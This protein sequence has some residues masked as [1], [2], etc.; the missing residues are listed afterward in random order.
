MTNTRSAL[1]ARFR[2]LLSDER[3][4]TAIEYTIMASGIAMA[5]IGTL[6]LVSES[7]RALYDAIAALF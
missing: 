3:G 6:A 5:I 4:A 1:S 2:Q 7:V